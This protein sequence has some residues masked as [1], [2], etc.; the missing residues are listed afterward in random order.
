MV[1][2]MWGVTPDRLNEG[3]AQRVSNI[4]ILDVRKNVPFVCIGNQNARNKALS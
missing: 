1:M 4:F 2:N 3:S